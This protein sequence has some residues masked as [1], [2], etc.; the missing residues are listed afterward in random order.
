MPGPLEYGLQVDLL[1]FDSL[2]VGRLVEAP[3]LVVVLEILVQDFLALD[4]FF[5]RFV[6]WEQKLGAAVIAVFH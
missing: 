5:V 3:I 1:A 2:V 4:G 6:L